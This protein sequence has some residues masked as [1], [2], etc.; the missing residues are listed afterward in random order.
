MNPMF[1]DPPG[2]PS[3]WGEYR[4]LVLAELERL[5]R[6]LGELETETQ[7][8]SVE[9]TALNTKATLWGAAAGCVMAFVIA[10]V[11]L[12]VK[13][14]DAKP[15]VQN[16]TVTSS[17]VLLERRPDGTYRRIEVPTEGPGPHTP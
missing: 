5:G 17:P 12:L 4:L 7:R 1:P 8:Q 10:V 11:P 9:I 13:A 2:T 15:P 14:D 3:Q 6:Q 16:Q